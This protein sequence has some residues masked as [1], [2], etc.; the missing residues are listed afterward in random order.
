MRR[1][2]SFD[3]RFVLEVEAALEGL[4]PEALPKWGSMSRGDLV[5]HLLAAVRYSLGEVPFDVPR[6]TR[7]W[8][9]AILRWLV[10]D[11]GLRMPRN[12]RFRGHRGEIVPLAKIPGG[13]PELREALQRLAGASSGDFQPPAHPY[14]GALSL[15]QW[16]RLHVLHIEHHL[17]QFGRSLG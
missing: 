2:R 4:A 8:F 9:G 12:V 11:L 1:R 16:E 17:R 3:E 15:A 5:A 14:L 7:P 6:Q 13:M 10:L